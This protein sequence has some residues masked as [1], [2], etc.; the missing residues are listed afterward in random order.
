[1]YQ[2]LQINEQVLNL[3]R[4]GLD[5]FNQRGFISWPATSQSG[6]RMRFESN[7]I[8]FSQSLLQTLVSL[9]N[10]NKNPKEG[11]AIVLGNTDTYK[12]NMQ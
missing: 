6:N 11:F 7:S 2:T 5:L 1:M 8:D 10:L 9:D 3:N 4:K 12:F